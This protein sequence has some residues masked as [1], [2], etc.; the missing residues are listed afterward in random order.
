MK[1]I[2]LLC[3]LVFFCLYGGR[4]GLGQQKISI[5]ALQQIKDHPRATPPNIIVHPG[6]AY[7][8]NRIYAKFK[9]ETIDGHLEDNAYKEKLFANILNKYHCTTLNISAAISPGKSLKRRPRI[10]Y[11]VS[12]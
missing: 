11:V 1:Y 10:W 12:V 4:E 6:A 8:A 3:L 5:E 2:T 9:K 7:E